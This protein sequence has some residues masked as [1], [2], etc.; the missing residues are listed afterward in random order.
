[1]NGDFASTPTNRN[2]QMVD[3]TDDQRDIIKVACQCID[4]AIRST[5]AFDR[6]GAAANSSYEGF[7]STRTKRL[8]VTN[9]FGTLHA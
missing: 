7:I 6:V 9:I 3:L 2:V 8:L 5:I 4:S 1:M